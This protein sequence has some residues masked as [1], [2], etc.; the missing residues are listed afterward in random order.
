MNQA[1]HIFAKDTRHLRWEIAISLALVI[2]Y[3]V[4]VPAEWT[5]PLEGPTQMVRI[6]ELRV[7]AGLLSVLM[8]VSWWI[9]IT[10]LVQSESLVGD[11]QWWIT[12]PYEWS[13]LLGSK[14]LFLAAFI[15]L[16]IVIAKAVTLAEAGFTPFAH[17]PGLGYSLIAIVAFLILPLLAIAAVTSTFGRATLTTLGVFVAFIALEALA[18]VFVTGGFSVDW[19]EWIVLALLLAALCSGIGLQ[20]AR[21][22]TW[23]AR[24]ILAAGLVLVCV[25]TAVAG[26]SALVAMTYR[27][28]GSPLQ[29]S[30]NPD[31]KGS[32]FTQWAGRRLIGV[33]VPI[34]VSGIAAGTAVDLNAVQ[35]TAEAADGRRWT[36]NWVPI[37]GAR[38]RAEGDLSVAAPLPLQFDRSFFAAEQKKPVT[39]HLRFAVT[40][41]RAG[42]PYSVAMP[43]QDFTVPGFGIC[44]PVDA[45][46]LGD[47]TD[48]SCRN[49]LRQP[50]VTFVT[51]E[52]SNDP[53]GS[54]GSAT[55]APVA[56]EGWA[57]TMER[58]QANF[59]VNGVEEV[60]IQLSNNQQHLEGQQGDVPRHLCP[61]SPITFT[62]YSL[63]GRK[64]Y[65]VTFENYQMP[66][67]PPG[68]HFGD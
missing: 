44:T 63:S 2:A 34:H 49:A 24:V 58:N 39:L 12:K 35:V 18:S 21:R 51:V 42:T 67:M 45:G 27:Q 25:A 37:W 15:G 23:T 3:V 33:S 55:S 31:S 54:V 61:G 17:L 48:L 8:G 4:V 36:S 60:G 22:K 30:Y 40:E 10:R 14:L 53:C 11:R 5:Q 46:A 59:G 16:P 9:L 50:S 29:L 57:G 32:S 43:K 6:Q 68:Y 28:S 13:E 62:P 64:E 20:Y 7:L 19:S 66:D 1:G 26:S 52:W 47:Y 56:G 65:D 38:Y 41:L